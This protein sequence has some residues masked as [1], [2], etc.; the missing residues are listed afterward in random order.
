MLQQSRSL[1]RTVLKNEH[2]AAAIEYG[3]LAA[4][5]GVALFAGASLLGTSLNTLFTDIG[6]FLTG[7]SPIGGGGS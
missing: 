2:G 5:V 7:V 1:M 4:L 6:T 3:L